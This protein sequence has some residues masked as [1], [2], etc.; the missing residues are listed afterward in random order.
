[1]VRQW[2]FWKELLDG[3]EFKNIESKPQPE[4]RKDWWNAAWI[5]I[6]HDGGGNHQCLDLAPASKGKTGQIITMWHDGPD[7]ELIATSFRGW[8]GDFEKKLEAGELK[9]SEDYGRIMPLDMA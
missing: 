6:T 4:I 8:L 7:R 1:M 2:G 9:Y 5:P 3:G